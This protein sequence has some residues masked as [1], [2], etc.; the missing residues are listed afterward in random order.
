MRTR[1]VNFSLWRGDDSPTVE[2]E[3]D[4]VDGVVQA[5]SGTP[6]KVID[7]DSGFVMPAFRDGH[8]HPL[9]AGR[10]HLGPDVTG[11]KTLAE[12]QAAVATYAEANPHEYWLDGAAFDR[13]I[14]AK[15]TRQELD[16]VVADRP[17]VLHGGDHHT[18]WVNTK[19][20]ELAGILHEQPQLEVGSVDVDNAGV[21]TGML[22]EWQAMQLVM[23]L[24]P[25]LDLEAELSCLAW[26]QSRLLRAGVVEVQDAWIDRGMTEI[27]LEAARRNQL[28]ITTHLAFRADPATWRTDLDYFVEMRNQTVT[29]GHPRLKANAI[30]FFVDG[31]FGSSTALV[32][33][34]YVSGPAAGEHGEAVWSQDE[35]LAAAT[36]ANELGFQLHMH[37]IGDS[38]VGRALDLVETLG[39]IIPAVIAHT[40]LVKPEDLGRFAKLNVIANFEPLWARE[41]G[42]LL[43]CQHQLGRQRL[44]RMYQMRDLQDLGARLS[45]GSDWPVS[46]PDALLGI[47]TAVNRCVQGEKSWTLEQALTA[48]EA[49]LA[50]TRGSYGQFRDSDG[51]QLLEGNESNF[52]VLDRDPRSVESQEL[53][54]IRIKRVVTSTDSIA[55]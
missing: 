26:A 36:A 53:F 45:F 17:V 46:S 13:S 34:P 35:F 55:L 54:E 21:A 3:F 8:C 51:W 28:S 39:P 48:E 29:A 24:I 37:A 40:E 25:A 4:V 16:A 2:S 43:S 50:Y 9:F 12:V 23:K 44:D 47:A 15:F 31:V 5:I 6:D 11:S 30:K 49:L 27:Y 14:E 32:S 22:R 19:A 41:D 20:L 42:Q 38:A 18:L 33:E 7:L 10:E 1:Y 52:V